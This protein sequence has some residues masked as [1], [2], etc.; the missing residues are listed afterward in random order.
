MFFDV[1][2]LVS[3]RLMGPLSTQPRTIHIAK[4]AQF[5]LF[6]TAFGCMACGTLLPISRPILLEF[7]VY[8]YP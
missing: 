3:F 4:G 5:L 2:T 1:V 7:L 6:L 8:E